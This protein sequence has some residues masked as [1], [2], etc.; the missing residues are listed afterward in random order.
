MSRG[1]HITKEE[2]EFI[3]LGFL[4]DAIGDTDDV[5]VLMTKIGGRPNR[6]DVRKI[7]F[8]ETIKPQ[9][10][11]CG[12]DQAL[13][14]QAWIALRH[15]KEISEEEK[16]YYYPEED[17]EE[18]KEEKPSEK[19]FEESDWGAD[20]SDW[21]AEEEENLTRDIEEKL[22]LRDDA[23]SS[24]KEKKEKRT[25]ET[26]GEAPRPT[27]KIC[28][29]RNIECIEVQVAREEKEEKKKGDRTKEKE[30]LSTMDVE[31][32]QNTEEVWGGE[33]YENPDR[34]FNKFQKR[35]E[36]NPE[37]ILRYSPNGQV[38]YT[39][40]NDAPEVPPCPLCQSPRRFEMQILPTLISLGGIQ[41][42]NRGESGNFE[43]GNVILFT[44]PNSCT[45]TT[46]SFYSE[47]VTIENAI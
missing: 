13:L 41:W 7:T 33:Q 16:K 40:E 42:N 14:L 47:F 4:G 30:I 39:T 2:E 37:Q 46:S 8:G 31:G 21:G 29:E 12:G 26:A 20:S 45:T 19:L 27:S 43:F 35:V 32:K 24:K 22:A 1:H 5:D 25:E 15:Q 28:G 36:K 11:K 6:I 9:C 34:N 18:K 10:P 23:S 44:C 3:T 17:K 38:L